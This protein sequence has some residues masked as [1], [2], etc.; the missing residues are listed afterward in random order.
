MSVLVTGGAGFIGSH[1]IE[2]MLRE[3]DDALICIDNFN[4]YYDPKLKRSNV[5]VF[6]DEP[7]VTVLESDFTDLENDLKILK[8]HKVDRVL[9]LGA[10][11]GVRASVENPRIYQESNV[12]GTLALLEAARQ[13]GRLDRFLLVSSSTVY[14]GGADVPFKE[15]APLGIP[16]SPYG[17]TKRSAELFGLTYH[18]LHDLPVVCLRPFSVY[19]PR[20]RPDLALSIFTRAIYLGDEFPLYGD[21]SFRRDFTHV[22]DICRGLKSALSSPTAVGQEINLGNDNPVEMREIIERLEKAL[23]KKAVIDRRPERPEDLPA[24]WADLTK[25]RELLGYSP[26]V[27][28][29]EGI[30][31][32]AKWYVDWYGS[33]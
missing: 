10:Y 6:S 29:D 25:A 20:I 7:R 18:A 28:L 16:M 27:K 12:A 15:N 5:A 8:D 31:E 3:S 32:F 22:S 33:H 26:K 2:L 9:H 11:A 24:T 13:Y 19:G 14:G 30:P 1:F 17:A 23:G 21:G 4:S